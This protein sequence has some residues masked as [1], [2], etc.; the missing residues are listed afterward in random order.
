MPKITSEAPCRYQRRKVAR[1]PEGGYAHGRLGHFLSGFANWLVDVARPDEAEH[2]IRQ[3]IALTE[4]TVQRERRNSGWSLSLRDQYVVLARIADAHNRP[5]DWCDAAKNQVAILERLAADFPELPNC[6][7]LLNESYYGLALRLLRWNRHSE[8][9]TWFAKVPETATEYAESA[10]ARAWVRLTAPDEKLR[11]PAE[12]LR[13]ST[14]GTEK[15][16][17][18][19]PWLTIH[20]F[21]QHRTGDSKTALATVERARKAPEDGEVDLFF[22][23]AMILHK[24]GERDRARQ[25]CA[26]AI[27]LMN[28]SKRDADDG[29]CAYFTEQHWPN[30][31]SPKATS[32]S[33]RARTTRT[34]KPNW[35]RS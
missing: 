33:P 8:A 15:L 6:R 21:A 4:K 35:S 23:H 2:L 26:A 25:Q 19:G 12:A 7:D 5:D 22:I 32:P 29:I 31:A 11:D 27:E 24:L 3:A 18:S 16:P 14:W 9:L 34:T 13:L 10:R 20:A 17:E 30:S 28:E 1:E